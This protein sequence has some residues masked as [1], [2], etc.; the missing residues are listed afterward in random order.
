MKR[1]YLFLFTAVVF[2]STP[3]SRAG[4][5]PFVQPVNGFKEVT[6]GRQVW[7]AENLSVATFRNGDTIPEAK[8]RAEWNRAA[9]QRKPA[10]C[11]YNNDSTLGAVYGK[12][13]NWFA[14]VDP[15]GLAPAGWHVPSAEEWLQLRDYLGGKR[16][17]AGQQLKSTTGWNKMG[18]GTNVTGF[19]ALPGGGRSAGVLINQ[20][21][22][23]L[24]L[25]TSGF[26][27]SS[28]RYKSTS[29]RFV[30]LLTTG[31]KAKY[32]WDDGSE[33]LSVRCV[34]D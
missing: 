13:Y 16:S 12:L 5:Q 20:N 8:T 24:A 23:F 31:K 30:F 28:N 18:N 4:K 9:A 3:F 1:F 25:G 21:E 34:K 29:D 2:C 7:M 27:W 22:G 6:I 17:N 11:Y 19:T 33:G 15:R 32:H 10:W 14:V 26:W